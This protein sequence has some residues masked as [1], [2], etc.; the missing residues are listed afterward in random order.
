MWQGLLRNFSQKTKKPFLDLSKFNS[1]DNYIIYDSIEGTKMK[2]AAL[3]LPLF[4][5]FSAYQFIYGE[6][7]LDKTGHLVFGLLTG[8]GTLWM[9][10]KS[11]KTVK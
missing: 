5:G 8:I 3:G 7:E 1:R 4:T 10:Y 2:I 9:I 6:E 11:R